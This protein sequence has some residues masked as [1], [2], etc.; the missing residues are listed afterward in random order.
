VVCDRGYL[1]HQRRWRFAL[2]EEAECAVVQVEGD[3]VVPVEVASPKVEFAARTLRPKINARKAAFLKTLPARCPKRS[4]P[5][6]GPKGLDVRRIEVIL[7]APALAIDQAVAP[8]SDLFPGGTAAARAGL[9]AFLGPVF[10]RYDVDR[11]RPEAPAVSRLSPYLH[12][13]QISPVEVALAVE[14]RRARA[15][16][17]AAAGPAAVA[18]AR[19]AFLEE[20]LV[21]RELAMNYVEFT[22]EYDRFRALPAWAQATLA[23]HAADRR[24]HVY[25]RAQLEAAATHDR[26]WNAAMRDMKATGYL[27]NA[28]RMYWGKKILEW[29][30]TPENAFDT[31]LALNNKYFLDGRDPSSYANVAWVFG[32]H[33]RPFAER[34][35]YGKVRCMMASGLERK[36]DIAAYADAVERR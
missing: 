19:A 18:A 21:R 36:S 6:R 13:G 4:A 14:A 29:S 27:H 28:L 3:V 25:S 7:A 32:L 20:L 8:V 26:Y 12:F 22:D 16:E 15:G 17:G 2:A 24:P 9:A 11:A 10:P 5:A 31:A 33:D 35:I 23:A 30:D 34:A 1:R